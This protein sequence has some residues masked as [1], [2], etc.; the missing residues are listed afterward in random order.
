MHFHHCHCAVLHY[1]E[2]NLPVSTKKA[3]NNQKDI[4]GAYFSFLFFL[5]AQLLFC[6][7]LPLDFQ[8]HVRNRKDNM[9][10]VKRKPLH[11]C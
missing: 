6:G 1:K 8:L 11:I 4:S 7:L 9:E 5:L 10:L 2:G 3:L